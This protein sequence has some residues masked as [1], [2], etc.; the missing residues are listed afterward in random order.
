MFS[1][2]LFKTLMPIVFYTIYIST[3]TQYDRLATLIYFG[4]N[5]SI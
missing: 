1:L 3:F 2:V 4:V 5:K